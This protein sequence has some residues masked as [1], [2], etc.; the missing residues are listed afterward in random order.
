MGFRF[1]EELRPLLIR[2]IL[3]GH[4]QS[5]DPLG[6]FEPSQLVE[7]AKHSKTFKGF[8]AKKEELISLLLSKI[9]HRNA[10]PID[11]LFSLS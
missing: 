3:D 5:I 9:D 10:I 8:P 2:K 6:L 1:V 7:P 4:D 11:D